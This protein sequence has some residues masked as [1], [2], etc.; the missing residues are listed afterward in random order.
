MPEIVDL[1]ELVPE[2]ITF[3]YHGGTYTIPGDL[4]V[5]QTLELYSLLQK[6]AKAEARGGAAELA[7]IM[8]QVE[9]ALLPIFQ[10]HEPQMEQLPFGA[11]GLGHVLRRILVLIGLLEISD[12]GEA[13][14]PPVPAPKPAANRAARRASSSTRKTT[15]P[16]SPKR[17]SPKRSAGSSR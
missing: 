15:K 4:R 9:A 1:D 3:K 17:T 11:A 12:S 14:N 6:L 10:V 8:R 5:D 2:D 7:K 16:G 13:A